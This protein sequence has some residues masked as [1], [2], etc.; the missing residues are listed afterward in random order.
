MCF[1]FASLA[2]IFVPRRN[3]NN[4]FINAMATLWVVNLMRASLHLLNQR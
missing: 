2:G 4:Y 1:T 3:Q